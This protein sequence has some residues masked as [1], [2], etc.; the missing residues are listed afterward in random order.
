MDMSTTSA[1]DEA[2]FGRF[3]NSL[4]FEFPDDCHPDNEMLKLQRKLKRMDNPTYNAECE[5]WILQLYLRRA[6]AVTSH[7]FNLPLTITK[8]DEKKQGHPDFSCQE[9]G[10]QYGLEVT[11]STTEQYQKELKKSIIDRKKG[12][13]STLVWKTWWGD[14]PQRKWAQHTADAIIGK[15]NKLRKIYSQNGFPVCDLIGYS[16]PEAPLDSE[17]LNSAHKKLVEIIEKDPDMQDK[18]KL[19]FRHISIV[20]EGWTIL[21]ILGVTPAFLPNAISNF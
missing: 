4:H 13:K 18:S 19:F 15:T 2:F 20:G 9:S 1:K 12:H 10:Q 3:G 21:D 5:R 16:F 17:D 8:N 7:Y 14:E 11:I 6:F